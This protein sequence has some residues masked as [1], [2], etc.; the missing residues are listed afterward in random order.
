MTAWRKASGLGLEMQ[1]CVIIMLYGEEETC[2][3]IVDLHPEAAGMRIAHASTYLGVELG[4][5]GHQQQW[6]TVSKKMSARLP[7]ITSA[8]S[9][10]SRIV[11]FTSYVTSLYSFKAKF[12]DAPATIRK[13]YDRAVQNIT[14]APWQALPTK[15]LT[16]LKGLRFPVEVRDIEQ[17]TYEAQVRTNQRS[18][19]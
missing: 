10:C 13:E 6:L 18:K 8:P 5:E 15:L 4:P 2:K 16:K 11:F 14:K 12:A 1:K 19:V 7:D 3:D 17:L 9:L